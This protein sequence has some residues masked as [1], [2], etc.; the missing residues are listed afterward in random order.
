MVHR[1]RADVKISE[2]IALLLAYANGVL[3][4]SPGVVSDK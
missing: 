3:D 4:F 1:N 2:A